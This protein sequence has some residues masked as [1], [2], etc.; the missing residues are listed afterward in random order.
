MLQAGTTAEA[1]APPVS[2]KS[3]SQEPSKEEA[4][5]LPAHCLQASGSPAGSAASDHMLPAWLAQLCHSPCSWLPPGQG[6]PC[7][8]APGPVTATL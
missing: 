1:R 8:A 2:D 7:M 4:L 5:G 3:G 6:P